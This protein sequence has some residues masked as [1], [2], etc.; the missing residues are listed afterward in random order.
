M[1]HQMFLGAWRKA[2][3]LLSGMF[4]IM[5]VSHFNSKCHAFL[6]NQPVYLS[7]FPKQH[8]QCDDV[9]YEAHGT[10][11]GIGYWLKLTYFSE[12]LYILTLKFWNSRLGIFETVVI[13]VII[14]MAQLKFSF[15]EKGTKI[16]KNLPLVL[17]LLSKN[18]C[19][20]K[21]SG[22][23]F[24]ILWPSHNV[25]TLLISDKLKGR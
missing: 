18:S 1:N 15:S 19:F 12:S 11:A 5:Q 4:C 7:P 3:D 21:T 6:T 14:D 20:V 16:W 24:P 9:T 2:K 25:L 10:F 13:L 23:F 17:T 22:R 8:T